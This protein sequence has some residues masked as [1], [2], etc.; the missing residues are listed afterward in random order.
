M[1]TTQIIR[2]CIERLHAI[3]KTELSVQNKNGELM[4]ATPGMNPPDRETAAA[5]ARSQ[6]DSQTMGNRCLL[7]VFEE[8]KLRYVLTAMGEQENT[9]LIGRIAADQLEQLLLAYRERY[10]RNSYFQ[11]LLLGHLG[12][13]EMYQRARKLRI[14]PSAERAVLLFELHPEQGKL[15]ADLLGSLYSAQNGDYLTQIEDN[16]IVLIK[17]LSGPDLEEELTETARTAVDM[18]NMEAMIKVRAACGTVARDLKELPDSC[19][20]AHMA[21]DVGK[22]FYEDRRILS[23]GKLG[24]GRLIYELPPELCR[25]FLRE[26]FGSEEPL[27]FDDETLTT[28]YTFLDNNLNVSET[29]RKLFLHRNTL[30]YRIEKIEKSTGL[31]VRRFEDALLLRVSLMISKYLQGA[32]TQ[33]R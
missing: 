28:I 30:V 27:A 21:L 14:E 24:V 18:L 12:E 23:C 6:A 19:R 11:S 33:P 32:G 3:T 22:L 31:D 17:S 15:A 13:T 20:Q 10:D 9:L 16:T 29:A 26:V 2:D 8:E 5:F 1:I 25:S 7:K 4:A